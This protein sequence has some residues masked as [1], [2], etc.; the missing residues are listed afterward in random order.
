MIRFIPDSPAFAWAYS[1]VEPPPREIEEAARRYDRG[2]R[3]R[4]NRVLD[5]WEVWY[6]KPG[7]TSQELASLTPEEIS[8]KFAFWMA[9]QDEDGVP[10]PLRKAQLLSALWV[11]DWWRRSNLSSRDFER[12]LAQDDNEPKKRAEKEA[13]RELQ[14]YLV[15][16]KNQLY[17]LKHLHSP[18]HASI[19]R[20]G[21]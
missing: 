4:F 18:D 6:A 3:L 10:L 1:P 16:H 9:I 20:K 7:Y 15:D 5:R 2:V 21:L 17:P 8:L 11:A 13:M 12:V 19:V 14:D